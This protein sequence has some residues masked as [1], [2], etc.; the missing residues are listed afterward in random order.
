MTPPPSDQI[1]AKIG[2]VIRTYFVRGP[3]KWTNN[4]PFPLRNAQKVPKFSPAA[5]SS[6]SGQISENKGGSSESFWPGGPKMDQKLTVSPLE[7]RKKCKKIRLRRASANLGRS[8]KIRGG[9]SGKGGSCEVN[10]PDCCRVKV[11]RS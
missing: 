4:W 7:T 5:G 9:S 1:L 10:F 11:S 2:G 8:L 3:Q 6:K